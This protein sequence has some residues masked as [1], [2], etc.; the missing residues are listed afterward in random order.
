MTIAA[1]HRIWRYR[2]GWGTHL[3]WPPLTG[4]C[5]VDQFVSLLSHLLSQ[6]EEVALCE[7]SSS[8]EFDLYMS[9]V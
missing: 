8:G 2:L 3:C 1:G 4:L 7:A 6:F 9:V 5:M